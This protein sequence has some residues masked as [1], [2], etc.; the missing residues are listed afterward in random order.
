MC[1][2]VCIN[3][4]KSKD[5]KWTI[6]LWKILEKL[7]SSSSRKKKDFLRSYTSDSNTK[8]NLRKLCARER[9][10]ASEG[11]RGA[12]NRKKNF[13]LIFPSTYKNSQSSHRSERERNFPYLWKSEK[14]RLRWNIDCTRCALAFKELVI[15]PIPTATTVDFSCFPCRG[16]LLSL[17]VIVARCVIRTGKRTKRKKITFFSALINQPLKEWKNLF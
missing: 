5:F 3:W 10:R 8:K 1:A 9:E 11:K 17:F 14:S 12:K 4:I 13:T 6:L 2:L 7:S 16:P 15:I